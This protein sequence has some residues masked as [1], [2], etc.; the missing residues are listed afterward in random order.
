MS[1][2]LTF[3]ETAE[4]WRVF[5]VYGLAAVAASSCSLYDSSGVALVHEQHYYW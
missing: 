5:I 1:T 2:S 3:S 4:L